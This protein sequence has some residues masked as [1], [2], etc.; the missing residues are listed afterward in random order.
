L[1]KLLEWGFEANPYDPCVMN[2]TVEGQKLTVAWHV[3][4]LKVSHVTSTVVDQFIDD[5]ETHS[6][7]TAVKFTTISECCSTSQNQER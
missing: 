1:G 3:D 5:M 2:K 7:N 4:D 6:T